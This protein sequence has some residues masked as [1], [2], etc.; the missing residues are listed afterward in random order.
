MNELITSVNDMIWTY[1]LIVAV[2]QEGMTATTLFTR[3]GKLYL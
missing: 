2:N 1:V 3:K